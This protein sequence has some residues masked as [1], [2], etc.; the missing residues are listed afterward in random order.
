MNI[1]VFLISWDSVYKSVLYTERQLLGAKVKYTVLDS[2]TEKESKENWINIGDVRFY[3]QLYEA[4]KRT[5][6][7]D[8]IV[9]MLG[10]ATFDRT[11]F[12]IQKLLEYSSG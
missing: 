11:D 9:F 1:H 10:D 8:Y 3:G 6:N 2:G 7:E 12:F 5:D 4:L